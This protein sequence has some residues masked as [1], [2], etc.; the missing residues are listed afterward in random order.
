MRYGFLPPTCWLGCVLVSAWAAAQTPIPIAAVSRPEPVRFNTDV[1]PI[2]RQKCLAC[3]SASEREGELVLETPATMLKGG[4]TG[5]A[6]IAGNG[7]ESLLLKLASHSGEPFMP[8]PDNDV[9]AKP[10]TSEELGLLKLWIDQ[11]ATADPAG[12]TLSPQQWRPLP[13]GVNPIYAVAVTPDG[14]FAA[15]GRANQ[16]FI[17]HVPTGQLVTR[18]TDPA[19]QLRDTD[20]RPGIA[21]LDLVQSL[22][23]NP[24]GDL[25]ASGG[26]R[27]VKLWRRPRDVVRLKL[28]AAQQA[29]TAVAVSPDQSLLAVAADLEI[30][31]WN[32]ATGEL[33]ATLAGH[34]APITALRFAA[35]Q[36]LLSA[37]QDKTVRIWSLESGTLVSRLDAPSPVNAMALVTAP[38]ALQI[39]EPLLAIADDEKLVRLYRQPSPPQIWAN[40]P[41]K[42]SVI[43][44]SP[45]RKLL[46][47]ANGDGVVRI[48]QRADGTVV[49]E[50]TVPGGLIHDLAFHPLATPAE[51]A[52]AVTPITQLATASADGAVRLWDYTTGELR[53]V[54]HGTFAAVVS[55]AFR[56]D[57]KQLIAGSADGGSTLWNL[58]GPPVETW[59]MVL[60]QPAGLAV[61]SPD[62][63]RLAAAGSA[64][65]C[66]AAF[67]FDVETKQLTH[68]LYGHEGVIRSLAFS[69]NGTRLVTGS[70]DKSARIWD[71]ADANAKFPEVTRFN[72]H[73][74]EVTAVAFN[75]DATQ[76]LS[77]AADNSV[78]L[79]N[80]ADGKELQNCVGHTAAIVGVGFGAGNQPVSAAADKTIRVWNAANGQPARAISDPEALT[81]LAVSRDGTQL[82]VACAGNI[83]R[84]Y[85]FDNGQLQATLTGHTA[86]LVALSF[87]ADGKRILT[88][89]AARANGWDS[90][91][92]RLL[93]SHELAGLNAAAFDAVA[94]RYFTLAGG[95]VSR[96]TLRFAMGFPAAPQPV[97]SVAFHVNGSLAYVAALDGTLR[98]LNTT[99]GQPVFTA[100]HGAPIRDFA[101]SPDANFLVSAG[102][103]M[104]LKIWNS[105]NGGQAAPSPLAGFTA[106]VQS[107]SFT[108]DGTRVVAGSAAPGNELLAF[109]FATRTLDQG[110]LGHSDGVRAALA[111]DQNEILTLA[112]DGLTRGWRLGAVMKLAGHAL[113]VTSLVTVPGTPPQLIS[114]SDDGTLRQWNLDNGQVTRQLNHGGPVAAVALR[115]DGLRLASVSGNHTVK[116][117]N[118]QNNQQVAEMRGD[119][120]AKML[121]AKLTQEQTAATVR[122]DVNK[123]RLDVLEKDLP[124][125]TEA[126]KKAADALTVATTDVTAKKTALAQ[127]ETAKVTAEKAAIDA[128]AVAQKALLAKNEA[129]RLALETAAAMKLAT[130]RVSRMASLVQQNPN[131][132]T[133]A[134]AKL[135]ADQELVA[136]TAKAEAAKTAQAAPTQM[137]TTTAQAA[138]T[139]AAKVTETQKPYNDA[140][141][142]LKQAESVQNTA[143]QLS[144]AA[145]REFDQA[146]AAVPVAKEALAASEAA[147]LAAQQQTQAAQQAAA[148]AELPWHAVAFS[149]DGR[150]LATSG[151]YAVVQMWDG[152]TG[153]AIGSFAG[154]QAAVRAVAF[155]S[156]SQLATGAADKSAL[157]WELNPNWELL[158]TIGKIDDP[159]QLVDRVLALDFNRDGT[160]LATGGGEPSRSGQ[161]KIWNVADGSLVRAIDNAHDDAVLGVQFSPDDKLL[162]S[163]GADKYVRT[164]NLATGQ[165]LRRF[166]GHTHHVLSVAWKGDGQVLASAGADKTIKIWDAVTADQQ[167]TIEGFGKQVTNV[168][169]IGDTLNIASSCGDKLVRLHRSNDGGNYR[170]FG[171]AVD[172]L[173]SVD[174]TPDE[175]IVIAG[176]H[177]S[178]LRVW[179]G[180]NGQALQ[181]IEPPVEGEPTAGLSSP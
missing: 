34:A 149:P 12:S 47:L 22:A 99:N 10:L 131:D 50:W 29:V 79:W 175:K 125:K 101:L 93:E 154:H 120:R 112:G 91:T 165:Q 173:H 116:L 142:A 161:I 138:T 26:F 56:A 124:P 58:E 54:Y 69:A 33:K 164:F 43:A 74:G 80:V 146:T 150:R 126:A 77:G 51:N 102:D 117:W 78:K 88:T 35:A 81:G 178:V 36:Q 6:V 84:L 104:T 44:A 90:T 5:P 9:A 127:T 21:H 25:L 82:A 106:P 162:A 105:G 16:I 107:V 8:P 171:G 155:V 15:C 137:A 48:M 28:A 170:N 42:A 66:P 156:D 153:E 87:S 135:M 2:L 167:R 60:G 180:A 123:Q 128:A 23:F 3:H 94:E 111:L 13:R 145:A 92:G 19:L 134:A 148:A 168:R 46:A 64:A 163:C 179:N 73:T 139:V 24:D 130:D 96:R 115:P 59:E 63:K 57:G 83:G 169:F 95:V 140:V 108:A 152:E 53:D 40:A 181:N 118:L 38:A 70:A 65:D 103:D 45:D 72:G 86:P 100:N 11:G 39:A 97:T 20:P 147:L 55:I 114:G 71:L 177:D 158:R 122:R 119:L 98:G 174:I 32:L 121:L 85:R 1:L 37:S 132:T 129:D 176:G 31:L 17:Y 141:V 18:L 113:R 166:E 136:A 172:F 75:A 7:N 52:G 62:G 159:A 41:G 157:V 49:K 67:V 61:L 133:I 89:D 27:E 30:K 4:D 151:D 109:E 143:A 68:T 160:L 144:A 76:V 14:Q 110:F